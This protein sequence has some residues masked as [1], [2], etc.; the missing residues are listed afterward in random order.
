MERSLVALPETEYLARIGEVAYAVSSLEWTILGDLGRLADALPGSLIL[1]RLEPMMT[2]G[3]A[4]EVRAAAK[5]IPAG[6]V[7]DYLDSVYRGLFIAAEI[8]SDV[9]HARPATDTRSNQRLSRAETRNGKTTGRR[10]WIDEQWFDGAITRLNEAI[11]A[12]NRDRPTL[13]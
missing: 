6:P 9:L 13:A 2:S 11:C 4:S 7:R 5:T 10:F 1:D 3:I 12:V 8:R